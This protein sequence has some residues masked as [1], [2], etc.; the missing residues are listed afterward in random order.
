MKNFQKW[1]GIAALYEAGAYIAGM[2]FFMVIV[3]YMSVVEPAQKMA[4]LLN[5]QAGMYMITL[6]C[7]VIFA[8]FLV[9]LSLALYQRLKDGSPAIMQTATAF[10]LIWA[11]LLIASGMIYNIGMEK[12]I[13]LYGTDPAQATTA[14][15]AIEAVHEGIGGGNEIIGGIWVL[16]IS[17]AALRTGKLSRGLNYIGLIIGAA[18]IISTIPPVGEIGGMIFGLGQIVWFIW[19]G[20]VLL[21]N[22]Q[23]TA[24]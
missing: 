24:V 1:G 8:L 23:T 18:G 6:A 16:L 17:L 21:R 15:L 11:A 2:V 22:K 3:D 9:L 19:L 14:W 20:I 12:V 13:D 4:L 7:Y 5:N 10:G